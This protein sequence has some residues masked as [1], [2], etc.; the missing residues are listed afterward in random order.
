MGSSYQVNIICAQLFQA[1]IYRH[2]QA[3]RI[4]TDSVRL[5]LAGLVHAVGRG[6]L[7]REDDLVAHIAR[8]HP[9]AQPLFR[10]FVLVV[11]GSIDEVAT[12]LVEGVEDLKRGLFVAFPES[13]FPGCASW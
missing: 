13:F 12:V 8:L 2:L 6:I 9:F 3:L 10:V 4:I 5:D 1:C 7:G 11:V